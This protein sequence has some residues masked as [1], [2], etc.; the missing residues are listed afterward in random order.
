MKSNFG[1]GKHPNSRNGFKPGHSGFGTKGRNLS[2]EHKRKIGAA[3]KISHLGLKQTAG[4]IAKRL[5]SKT[6]YKPS[7]A[8]KQ[9]MRLARLA[10][11]TRP[12]GEKNYNWKG[13]VTPINTAI[14]HS[15]EY[16]AWRTHVFQRD[17]YTCQGCGQVGGVLHADHELPFSQYPSLRFEILNGRTFCVSCHKKYGWNVKRGTDAIFYQL[18]NAI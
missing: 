1:H 7:E 18:S 3:N 5:A 13:G 6:G 17:N 10:N 8:T 11:P 15:K 16:T 9:K 4:H 14:R 2:E 12:V